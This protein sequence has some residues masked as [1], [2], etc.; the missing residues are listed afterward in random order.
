[1]DFVAISRKCKRERKWAAAEWEPKNLATTTY[2][3]SVSSNKM[4]IISFQK[5]KH[6]HDREKK[7]KQREQKKTNMRK[8]FG[9]IEPISVCFLVGRLYIL[10]SDCCCCGACVIFLL[11]A[12]NV[13]CLSSG[14]YIRNTIL[15]FL[16]LQ[17]E[18]RNETTKK[19]V[20][21]YN[22]ST[23]THTK[24]MKKKCVYFITLVR[25]TIHVQAYLLLCRCHCRFT[26]LLH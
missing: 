24:I 3:E 12:R 2:S 7:K 20:K 8:N 22:K 16:K 11:P 9:P 21:N 18:K 14:T 1:M 13:L 19:K 4:L 6:W 23:K 25:L 10:Y 26:A 5:R 15:S 17:S